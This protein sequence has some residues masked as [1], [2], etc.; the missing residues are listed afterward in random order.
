MPG[1]PV[2]AAALMGATVP[3][4][5]PNGSR[6]TFAGTRFDEVSRPTLRRVVMP[7]DF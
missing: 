1:P 4:A 5:D 6:S 3:L 7:L 2:P